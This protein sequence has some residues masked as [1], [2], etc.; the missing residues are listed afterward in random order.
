MTI[1][2]NIKKKYTPQMK[3]KCEENKCNLN[4]KGYNKKIILKGEK[5][6]GNN[7]KIC[8][9][10]IFIP[11]N[12]NLIIPI[13]ELKSNSYKAESIAEKFSNAMT[14]CEKV[15]CECNKNNIKRKFYLI[16]L[17]KSYESTAEFTKIKDTKI[18]YNNKNYPFVAKN[19]EIY[20][21]I[22]YKYKDINK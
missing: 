13:V 10:L 2:E 16:L 11:E 14:Q 21:K 5:L 15:L 18:P 1:L 12:E 4:L 22:L 8:D 6:V 7:C 17:A 9:C 19:V 3:C 20:L